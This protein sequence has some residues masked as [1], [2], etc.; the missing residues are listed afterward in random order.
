MEKAFFELYEAQG[1]LALEVGHNS[2]ADWNIHIYDRKEKALVECTSP[3]ISVGDTHREL[4]FA[5]A[6]VALTEYLSETRGGY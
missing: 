4:T 2:I 1:C 6:Y 3:V 5:K